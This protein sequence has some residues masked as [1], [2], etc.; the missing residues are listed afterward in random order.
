MKK[1]KKYILK[2]FQKNKP[3]TYKTNEQKQE[4]N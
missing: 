2:I 1:K 3:I 4:T